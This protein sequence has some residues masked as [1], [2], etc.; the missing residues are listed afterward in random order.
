MLDSP[1]VQGAVRK[2]IAAITGFILALVLLIAL[3][4]SGFYLLVKAATLA[5]SP[6]LGEAGAL[7]AIGFVCFV[8]LALFFYRM[9]RPVSTATSD[10]S[11]ADSTRRS[12]VAILREI[13]RKNPLESAFTAFA[14]GLVE[15][16]DPQL[17]SLL[18]QG[19]M[20]LM[21]QAEEGQPDTAEAQPEAE[22]PAEEPKMQ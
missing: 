11:G 5:M 10:A 20:V 16:S 22:A 6:F 2:I 13:I 15:N 4:I 3:L 9:T 1:Q 12:P 18:L 19:G 21:K 7:A 17:K 14:A 8:L